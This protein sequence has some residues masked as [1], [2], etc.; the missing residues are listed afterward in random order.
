MSKTPL[1]S[2]VHEDSVPPP[3]P[4]T[5]TIPAT[6][7]VYHLDI[8]QVSGEGPLQVGHLLQVEL[9]V[10]APADHADPVGDH[11]AAVED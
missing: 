11:L 1:R 3:P 7:P 10:G 4:T 9:V 2:N 6:S 8:P 5:H